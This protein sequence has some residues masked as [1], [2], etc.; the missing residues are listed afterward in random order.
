[1]ITFHRIQEYRSETF[2]ANP[3]YR[4]KSIDEAIRYV[5]TR[6]Y[7]YFWPISGILLPSLWEAVS[8]DRPVPNEHDDPGHVTWGWK[9]SM[10]GKHVWYYA[11]VLRKKATI[12]SMDVAPYFYA[13][14][15]NYGSPEEDYLTIYE[16]GRLTQEAKAVYEALLDKGPLDTISL[17]KAAHLTSRDSEARFTRALS[18]LQADFK[19]MPI[20]VIDAGAWHYAFVYDIVARHEPQLLENSRF[21]GE[22][23]A[24]QKILELYFRSLGAA[25]MR[26]VIKLFGWSQSDINLALQKLEQAGLLD[27]HQSVE[28]QSGDWIILRQLT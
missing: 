26:E 23:D 6:G 25:Q 11:K 8:G 20:E 4:V 1:M 28:G 16:Q 10:L 2:C 18:D 5:N 15:E 3:Q 17:K 13:L 9:D 24:R 22:L 14:T 27:N 19:I 7:I 21:L 12:I